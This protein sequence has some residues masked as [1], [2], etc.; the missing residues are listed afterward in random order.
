MTDG[1]NGRR[2]TDY[3]RPAHDRSSYQSSART[4]YRFLQIAIALAAFVGLVAGFMRTFETKAH[5]E[6]T[7]V[8]RDTFA[9]YMMRRDQVLFSLD[10]TDHCNRGI[11]EF[12]R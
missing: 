11:R 9:L 3:E 2:A 7:Y 1:H 12:C 4:L 8:Q 6:A 10:S 5:A